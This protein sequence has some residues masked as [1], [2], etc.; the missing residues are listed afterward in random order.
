MLFG[1]SG[2]GKSSLLR[3]RLIPC[4]RREIARRDRP[5]CC[6]SS[7]RGRVPPRRSR[8]LG[9]AVGGPEGRAGHGLRTWPMKAA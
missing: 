2:S 8:G 3:A 9:G 4:L 5:G 1:A 6:G 7:R